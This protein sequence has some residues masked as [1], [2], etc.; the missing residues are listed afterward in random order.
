MN[1]EEFLKSKWFK[2]VI[3]PIVSVVIITGL[4][5]SGH[6]FGQWIFRIFH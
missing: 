3:L 6:T 5:K 4:F 1:K 2:F